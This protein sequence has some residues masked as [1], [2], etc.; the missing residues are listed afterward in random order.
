MKKADPKASAQAQ[1]A[2][3]EQKQKARRQA[4][5]APPPPYQANGGAQN[6]AP[7]GQG[8][9]QNGQAMGPGAGPGDEDYHRDKALAHLRAAQAHANAHHSAKQL[10]QAGDHHE[11][12][13]DAE[14]ASMDA[15]GAD[16]LAPGQAAPQPGQ[17]QANG[18]ANGQQQDPRTIKKG[19]LYV[20]LNTA[21]DAAVALLEKGGAIGAD[22]ST[23]PDPWGP[24]R[25]AAMRGER[26]VKG[27]FSGGT[28]YQGEL[29]GEPRGG[30]MRE[31]ATRLVTEMMTVDDDPA[32]NDGQGGLDAW[33]RD[34]YSPAPEVRVPL[35]I[36]AR[37]GFDA[38]SGE[39]FGR[40]ITKSAPETVVIDDSD[41]Y[42]RAL[43]RSDPRDGQAG[44]RLAYQGDPKNR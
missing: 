7:Q 18:Q 22:F 19:N 6:G 15:V 40:V 25:T 31:S 42:Q 9:A 30:D 39:M 11:R 2:Q 21:D 32:G 26:I 8:Q 33:F 5:G 17:G 36:R 10:A 29:E 34:A 41:P 24:Q 23:A 27:Q 28:V 43:S 37:A 4:S 16:Q 44:M 13:N 35:D 14:A 20:D 38:P 1:A 3:E 12:V